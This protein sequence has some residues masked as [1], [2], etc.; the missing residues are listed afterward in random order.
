MNTSTVQK[1]NV[2]LVVDS[3]R[4][5]EKMLRLF[6][7]EN[8]ISLKSTLDGKSVTRLSMSLKPELILL[9]LDLPDMSGYDVITS[10]REWSQVPIIVLTARAESRD[11][12][13]ALDLGADDYITKPFNADVMEERIKANL[14]KSAFRETGEVELTNGPLR[15]DL[16]RH[17]VYINDKPVPFTPKEY[18]LL[19]YFLVN[20]GKMLTHRS[21]LHEVW[22]GAHGDD[23]QYLRVFVSQIRDK[24]DETGAMPSFIT[25]G[26]GIGY[27]ME[28]MGSA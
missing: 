12:V 23:T 13:M 17:K 7:N 10:L 28:A 11:V 8:E 18:N 20:R 14:R 27:C 19:R 5:T 2:V 6:L 26:A 21:L 24:I 1:K 4:Q 22:G 16:V 9:E 15:M 25:T 3:E